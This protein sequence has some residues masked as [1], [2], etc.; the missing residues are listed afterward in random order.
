MVMK[1]LG[2]AALLVVATAWPAASQEE[3]AE[4][5]EN[6]SF[7]LIAYQRADEFTDFLVKA[8]SSPDQDIP[9]RFD[10]QPQDFT[11]SELDKTHSDDNRFYNFLAMKDDLLVVERVEGGVGITT[12]YVL[13]VDLKKRESSDEIGVSEELDEI[14]TASVSF[15]KHTHIQP[16]R[17]NCPKDYKVNGGVKYEGAMA[18]IQR[19]ITLDLTSRKLSESAVL[20]CIVLAD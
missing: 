10:P 18:F 19:K 13:M 14:D 3:E 12:S 1:A 9:C 16:N 11:V 4:C 2:L 15:W 7:V 5:H 6:E 8:K 17:K 20:R